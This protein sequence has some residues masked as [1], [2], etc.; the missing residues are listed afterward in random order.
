MTNIEGRI[1]V[2]TTDTNLSG[3]GDFRISQATRGLDGLMA[4]GSGLARFQPDSATHTVRAGETLSEIARANG[5]DWQ[6]L[7]RINGLP[8]PDRLAIGQKL[9]LP[10]GGRGAPTTHVVTAGETVSGI[11]KAHGVSTASIASGNRLA[12]AD[13]IRPG[14]RLTIGGQAQSRGEAQA[15]GQAQVAARTPAPTAPATTAPARTERATTAGVPTPDATSQKAADIAAARAAGHPSIGRCYAWVK[16]ALQKSGAV[17]DY[18]P[19]V[20][21]KD[22]G[23]TLERR[24]FVNLLDRA[25]NG[26]GSPYDAPKGAV[27]VYG[28][29]PGARDA[30]AKYGHIEIRTD[31]GFASDYVSARARTGA[32]ANGL[33]GRGRTLIGVYVKPA[34]DVAAAA[35]VAAAPVATQASD[36]RLGNLSMKFE[37]GYRPGQEAAAAATVSSGIGDPGGKSY[38]AYQLTSSAG[39]GA[40][41]KAFLKAEGAPWAA[42]FEGLD[43]TVAGGFDT[44]WKAVAA[45]N[46]SAFFEAQHAYIERTH[47][48]RTANAAAAVGIDVPAQPQAVRDAL[49][50]MSV[51]HHGAPK[52][53]ATAVASLPDGGAS[54]P[55]E[56]VNALYDAREAYVRGVAMPADTRQSLLDRYVTERAD[57]LAMLP[58]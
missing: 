10:D 17:A 53:V 30:N 56:L 32:E 4:S 9:Q 20:A 18:M 55:R 50:S 34:A 44:A 51:Q 7:A 39:S 16:E 25:G 41:V 31:G 57:A 28:A 3:Q 35:P 27:L 14:Q 26:I 54:S 23:P 5:T 48:D 12:D 15:G 22:A 21:A 38:G 40:Q 37:T 43:P 52:I 1:S 49:W 58:Q 47:Y 45:E 11:A 42:R 46:P 8:D 19:G 6:T 33:E 2:R 36:T 13:V 29:A 24:G